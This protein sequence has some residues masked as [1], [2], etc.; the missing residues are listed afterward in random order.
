MWSLPKW[1]CLCVWYNGASY[2]DE[3]EVYSPVV[4][5]NGIRTMKRALAVLGTLAA[6]L[7]FSTV[8][9]A[10]LSGKK[11]IKL[12]EV[13]G[14]THTVAEIHFLPSANGSSYKIHWKDERFSDHFLSMRPFK[15][16]E[17][18]TKYW[19]RVPYPYEIRR[20][21]SAVDLTDLEYDLLFIWK[22]A[23]EYGINMW[24]GVYYK[25]SAEDGKLVGA[26]NEMDMDKLSA[27]PDD[28]NLRPIR[29]QDLEPGEPE[30]HWLPKLVIE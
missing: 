12:V 6:F 5:G 27:P 14:K 19:C 23:K 10:E 18:S 28:G 15:C 22:G 8:Q 2:P 1:P 17:G 25:I 24:N 7:D 9:A 21:V 16:L 4:V 30:S 20:Q 13:G 11:A 26:L 3:P 29:E